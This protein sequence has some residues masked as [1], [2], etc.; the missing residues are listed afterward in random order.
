MFF[1]VDLNPQNLIF[2]RLSEGAKEC[3]MNNIFEEMSEKKNT[4]D[5][6]S[7][8]KKRYVKFRLFE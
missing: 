1:D 6:G 4:I 8:D 5:N 7:I 3:P 2:P